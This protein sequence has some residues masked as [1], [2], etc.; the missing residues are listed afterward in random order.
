MNRLLACLL[1]AG[2]VA[3]SPTLAQSRDALAEV[4]RAFDE[5]ALRSG[6]D[7]AK[8]MPVR[9]WTGP[10]KLAFSNSSAAPT[11][12]EVSRRGVKTL[13]TEAGL[14]VIDLGDTGAANYVIHFDENGLRGRA[15]DCSA[16]GW[17]NKSRVLY[18]GQLR[19]NPARVNDVDRCAIHESMHSLGF[20]SHPHGAVS[21][22]SYVYKAQRSLTPL[23]KHLIGTLYDRRLAPGTAAAPAS[24]RACRILGERLGAAVADIEAVCRERKGPVPAL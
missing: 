19:I 8:P 11:L 1:L 7:N 20:F 6:D 4:A 24:Q 3:A 15:G 17:W 10:I 9:K 16:N 14:E 12:V 23:D 13:A 2:T 21:V 18:K 22:L 5:S